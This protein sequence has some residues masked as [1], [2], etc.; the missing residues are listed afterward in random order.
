MMEE[1]KNETKT[2]KWLSVLLVLLALTYIIVPIDFD[3]HVIG[4]F[5]DFFLFMASFCYF[6]SQFTNVLQHKAR[7]RLDMLAICFCILGIAWVCVLA[8]TPISTIVA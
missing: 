1:I 7:K 2:H 4:F 8:F 6:V 5:D 3:G